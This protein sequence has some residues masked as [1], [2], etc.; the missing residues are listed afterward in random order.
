MPRT[1]TCLARSDVQVET[2]VLR[3][4]EERIPSSDVCVLFP[5]ETDSRDFAREHNTIV[6]E[7][8]AVS[9]VLISVHAADDVVVNRVKGIMRQAGADDIS[10]D[11]AGG[12]DATSEA[13]RSHNNSQGRP[14][15]EDATR[16]PMN[17]FFTKLPGFTQSPPG[18]ERTVLRHLPR[19]LMVGTLILFVPSL[20]ARLYP[21]DGSET[22]V[23]L[24]IAN[25]DIYMISAVFLHL[26]I[27]VTVAIAAFIVMVMKGPA[28]VA[29]A[30]PLEDADSP[31]AARSA[32]S[33]NTGNSRRSDC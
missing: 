31:D 16:S 20:L 4:N 25:I 15:A 27:V 26:S 5:D 32:N 21:W 19:I 22:L 17:F 11:V 18:L 24:R 7:G 12:I 33:V 3:L 13:S 9:G 30:Y 28:Y 8:S 14:D 29:D 1:V 10:N 23:A 6:P 2:I